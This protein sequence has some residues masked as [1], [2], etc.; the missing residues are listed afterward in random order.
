MSS[1]VGVWIVGVKGGVATTAMCGVLSACAGRI[2]PVG[3]VTESPLAAGL[4]LPA[5]DDLVFGGHDIRSGD[6]VAQA[7]ELR[8]TAHTLRAEDLDAIEPGLRR[9]SAHCRPG[10]LYESGSAIES[11]ADDESRGSSASAQET[12][13]R[14]RTDLEEFRRNTGAARVVFVNLASTEPPIAKGSRLDTAEGV[15]SLIAADARESLRASTLYAVAAAESGCSY[16]NFTPSPG[17]LTPGIAELFT[18]AGLPFMGSDGKT[19]ETLLKSVLAPMFKHRQLRVHTWYGYNLLGDRDGLV[20][21]HAE[22]K[23]AKVA[24]KDNL[25]HSELG[26]PLRSRVAID[27]A[28]SLDDWKTAWDFIHFEGFLG[29]KMAM[30]FTWQGC[31]SILAAPLVLDMVRLLAFAHS[32]GERG[33]Q[34]HLASFFKTPYSVSTHDFPTQFAMLQSYL[35]RH[36]P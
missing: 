8:R 15:R 3:M 25:L 30:Q 18:D 22:N 35:A 11:L 9:F 16:L 34:T 26:A 36:Q 12:V 4:P 31:D 2:A 23:E 20:L 29:V 19:G 21:D 33:P 6:L 17:A 5:L 13:E 24:S 14:I 28:P 1:P 10:A 27:Y 7:K 32:R